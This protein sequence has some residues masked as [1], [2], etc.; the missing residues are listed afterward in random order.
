VGREE[1]V[2]RRIFEVT[3]GEKKNQDMTR[4]KEVGVGILAIL[5]KQHTLGPKRQRRPTFP[6]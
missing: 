2:V 5:N 3:W 4:G 6:F 1:K